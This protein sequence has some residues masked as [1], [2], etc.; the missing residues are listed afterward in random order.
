MRSAVLPLVDRVFY[1]NPELGRYV[2]N[3]EFL[4]YASVDVASEA[5]TLPDPGRLCAFSM[6]PAMAI[7]KAR[8]A[9]S[10]RSRL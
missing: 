5:V 3:G 7:S 10:L 4:P 6:R 1:L 9:F 2:P 8:H